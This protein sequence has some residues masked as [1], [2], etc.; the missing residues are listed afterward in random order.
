ME[1][2]SWI[3]DLSPASDGSIRSPPADD[4]DRFKAL[5]ENQ[6]IQII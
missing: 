3:S 5:K 4:P 1:S 6:S 2:G